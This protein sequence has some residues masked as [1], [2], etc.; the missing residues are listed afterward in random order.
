MSKKKATPAPAAPARPG[1]RDDDAGALAFHL[2]E[3]LRL[4]RDRDL[5]PTEFYNAA[6]EAANDHIVNEA[7]REC[8]S[9]EF[10]RLAPGRIAARAMGARAA[11]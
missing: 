9:F 5:V 4:A 8:D 6:G 7:A 2:S 10:L 3:V 1:T 11:A